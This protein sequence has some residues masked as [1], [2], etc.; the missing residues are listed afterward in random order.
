[1]SRT[2]P[3][4]DRDLLY[5]LVI[6][7]HPVN[8]STTGKAMYWLLWRRVISWVSPIKLILSESR[9]PIRVEKNLLLTRTHTGD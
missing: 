5:L 6:H 1:M 4:L 7:Q 2:D 9:R 3:I 8:G